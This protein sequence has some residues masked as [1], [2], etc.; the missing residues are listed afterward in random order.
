MFAALAI[1]ALLQLSLPWAIENRGKIFDWLV[2]LLPTRKG[3][4]G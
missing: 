1:A 2:S 4:G 3:G